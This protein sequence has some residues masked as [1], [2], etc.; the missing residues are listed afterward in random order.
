MDSGSPAAEAAGGDRQ[1]R[2]PGAGPVDHLDRVRRPMDGVAVL[3]QG[4]AGLA[5]QHHHR[6]EFV[7][8]RAA[9]PPPPPPPLPCRWACRS[10]PPARRRPGRTRSAPA[11]RAGAAPRGATT[12]LRPAL[13]AAAI[14]RAGT[15]PARVPFGVVRQH[16]HLGRRHRVGGDPHQPVRQ[17]RLDGR[18]LLVVGP[19][20]V[21]PGGHEAGLGGGGAAALDQ[22]PGL[23]AGLAAD[24]AGEVAARLVVAHHGHE[25][26]RRAEGG[27][28]AHHVAGAARQRDLP[29]HGQHRH[30]GFRADARNPA[31][32]VPVEHGVAHHQDGAAP[33]LPHRVG[34][35][36][37]S[38]RAR[39]WR[40]GCRPGA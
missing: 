23:H 18:E 7:R 8:R 25:G 38:A 14:S 16:H 9:P 12:T 40:R 6:A 11:K 32:D 21:L 10:P 36:G 20:H 24:Q 2:V 28:V 17:P 13:R 30:R 34:E 4:D 22:Q 31:V 39:A 26:H 29:L 37:G 27:E 19:Q 3:D 5:A 1:H 35:V 33:Q 15:S